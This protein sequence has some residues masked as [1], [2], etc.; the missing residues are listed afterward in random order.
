M[1]HKLIEIYEETYRQRVCV[2][3]GMSS[4]IFNKLV[5]EKYGV[6]ADMTE[7]LYDGCAFNYGIKS[8]GFEIYM[9][10]TINKSPSILA[11]EVLHTVHSMLGDRGLSL[12]D[13]SEEAY[14]YLTQRIVREVIKDD[15]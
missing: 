3:Y 14:A 11:H 15:K 2:G 4:K 13:S 7:D 6:E 10:W 9:I 5:K 12:S 8:G 1:A